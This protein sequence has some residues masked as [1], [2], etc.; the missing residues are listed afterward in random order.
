MWGASCIPVGVRVTLM[1][2]VRADGAL[3]G[4]GVNPKLSNPHPERSVSP[5]PIHPRSN[6][7]P[8]P[9]HKPLASALGQVAPPP[10]VPFCD[11]RWLILA[12][13]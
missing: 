11:C 5:G 2:V 7:S 3:S 4:D 8:T 12:R 13:I 9:N 10:T 6:D 1:P